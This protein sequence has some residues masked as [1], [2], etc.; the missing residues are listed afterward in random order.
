MRIIVVP[1]SL[2]TFSRKLEDEKLSPFE[3]SQSGPMKTRKD[4][5]EQ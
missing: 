5:M 4:Q 1:I 3:A 2:I